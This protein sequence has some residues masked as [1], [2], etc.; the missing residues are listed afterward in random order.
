MNVPK[1]QSPIVLVHGLLGYDHVKVGPWT[2]ADY[3]PGI[4]QLFQGA[5]NRV[6]AVRLSPTGGIPTRAAQLKTAINRQFPDEAVHLIAHSLGGLD[7]RY[8]I[9]RL[10]MA[11]RVLS[12]TTLGTPHRGSPFAD[13]GIRRLER[14]LKPMFALLSVP[15]QA[16]YDLTTARCAA[17]NR[18]V[19]DA[20]NVRYFSI[21][22]SLDGPLFAPAWQMIHR[23]VFDAEGPNDGL[24]SLTSAS[25]GEQIDRWDADHLGL[26]NW[27]FN[28]LRTRRPMPG[29]LPGYAAILERLSA[30]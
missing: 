3:W 26:A 9:S 21:A 2:F 19:P 6:F 7:A 12:L 24:V 30:G 22:G 11:P 18:E 1:L 4:P 17:F 13:W 20:P 14:L 15:D 5:G 23:I 27:P 25:Y 28:R 16:F 8:M 29:R 10:D